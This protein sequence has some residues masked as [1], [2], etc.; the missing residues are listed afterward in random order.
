M[1]YASVIESYFMNIFTGEK[2]IFRNV[3]CCAVACP[4]LGGTDAPDEGAA[5]EEPGDG[6]QEE[7]G[8]RVPEERPAQSG[9]DPS[10]K[11]CVLCSAMCLITH[12]LLPPAAPAEADGGPEEAARDD[13]AEEKRRGDAQTFFNRCTQNVAQILIVF[14]FIL[15][16]YSST[17]A[18]EAHVG[19]SNQEGEPVRASPGAVAQDSSPRKDALIRRVLVQW[20]QVLAASASHLKLLY[21][22]GNLVLLCLTCRGPVRAL[23]GHQ[24]HPSL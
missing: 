19:K 13:P 10:E 4:P 1:Q 16:G 3:C 15:I 18:G 21:F 11:C 7:Q 12:C 24:P 22:L 20:C 5:G 17:A 8:D 14:H 9:G 2:Y 6:V 23:S